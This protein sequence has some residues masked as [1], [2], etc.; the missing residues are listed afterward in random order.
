MPTENPKRIHLLGDG[1]HEEA[2]A[3]S[4]ITPGDL[5]ELDTNGKVK[6]HATAGGSAEAAFAL[7]DALQGNEIGDDYAA[8]A[9][10]G[11]VL[12]NRGD[13]VYA[14]LAAGETASISSKLASDGDGALRVVTGSDVPLAVALEAKDLS[15]SD[16]VDGRLRV[17]VL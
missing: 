7:E 3:A 16:A 10:V 12:A 11:F 5:I 6:R 8:A 14:T 17:R 1:R 9:R 15:D 2:I 4:T 13:V